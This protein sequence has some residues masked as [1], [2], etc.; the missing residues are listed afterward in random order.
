MPHWITGYRRADLGGDLAA[1]LVVT[2]ML[3]P[4]S[5]AYALLA[6]VPV[7]WG[8]YAS[9]LP[10][11][12]YSLSGTSRYLAVGPV[13]VISLM[14][15]GV[16]GEFAPPGSP[17]YLEATV[18]LAWLSGV[19]LCLFGVLR[20]GIAANLL[21]HTVIGGFINAAALV[22]AASQVKHLLGLDIDGRDAFFP[23]LG[24]IAAGLGDLNAA[25]ACLGIGSMIL[26]L[27]IRRPL[28][29]VMGKAALGEGIISVATRTGALFTV[30]LGGALVWWLNLDT[31]HGV[32]VA[33]A[34]PRGLPAPG[35]HAA[36]GPQWLDLAPGAAV[37][38]F[39]IYLESISV[40][41]S[42]ASRFR[43][44]VH[45]G[46]E[47]VALGFANLASALSGAIPVAGGFSRSVVN[48]SAGAR[49]Q[50][51][52]VVTAIGTA[53]CILV[54]G[55]LFAFIPNAVLAAIV[56]ISVLRLVDF[57]SM[58]RAWDYNRADA[59]S[60]AITFVSVLLFNV[61]TGVLCGLL[62]SLLIFLWRT[63]HPHFAV[64]GRVADTEHYRNVLMHDVL[65]CPYVVAIRIDE[66]LYFANAQDLEERILELAL[67]D[68]ETRHVVLVCSAVNF[69]DFSAL[70]SLTATVERLRDAGITLHLAEVKEPV[71]QRLEVAGFPRRL[72]A[73]RVFL[74]TH[75]A[76][77]TLG[78]LDR[79]RPADKQPRST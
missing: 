38:A 16:A 13:A 25:T 37:I 3:V 12:I 64:L 75:E 65:T 14:V 76:M 29:W 45:P 30:L 43:Q 28:A 40:A 33:G 71:M 48:L 21:S 17:A 36:A 58:L 1:G 51:A 20:L 31:A 63:M 78:C 6:G 70:E 61:E 41:R 23:L 77:R 52:G 34:V 49:T 74:S 56:V 2:I 10:L 60:M 18:I 66:S 39:V 57:R 54:L 53:L 46:R 32:Q 27:L 44:R 50:F 11:L 62:F 26:L 42:L 69:I 55:P 72:G 47:L 15:A 35:L 67:A 59:I 22:I 8:L 79:E 19:F 73:G 68:R 5:M 7:Q 4:Q 24:Q 9:I